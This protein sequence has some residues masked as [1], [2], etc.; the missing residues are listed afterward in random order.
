MPQPKILLSSRAL[1]ANLDLLIK[2]SGNLKAFPVLKANAYGLGLKEVVSVLENYSEDKLPYY[3]VA[4]TVELQQL[5]S[6]G[7]KR[8]LLLLSEWPMNFGEI[9]EDCE[10][11][12]TSIEDLK[13]LLAQ[14]K[15]ISY[16]LKINSGMNRLG[17]KLSEYSTEQKIAELVKLIKQ[18]EVQGHHCH[19]IC[20]HLASG[21]ESPEK[22]SNKQL[23]AFQKFYESLEKLLQKNFQW[24]HGLNSPGV[25][26]KLS[27]QIPFNGFRPGIHLWGIRDPDAPI[28]IAPV[29]QLRAPIR[30]LYWIARGESV[31][32]GRKYTADKDT[33]IGILNIGYADGLRRDAWSRNLAFYYKG[34]KA[35][36]LGVISMDMCAVDLT[37]IEAEVTPHSEFEWIGSH[38]SPET[39]A[40]ALGTIPYEILT[41][42]SVRIDR[43]VV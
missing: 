38:Q 37:N 12:V 5:R 41:S 20:T 36:L 21:E 6:Y 10:V 17:L 1:A 33:R 35:P 28:D 26:R 29:V 31:G 13:S 3:C 15:Q 32:Y 30:Q 18:A 7:V 8:N 40:R 11:M 19:G 43:Q 9:P 16:H 25:M 27:S 4:R 39:I 23:S 34:E 24:V 14:K 42:L 2:L 22:F